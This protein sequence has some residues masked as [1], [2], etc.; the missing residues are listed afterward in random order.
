MKLQASKLGALALQVPSVNQCSLFKML[1]HGGVAA[2]D[3]S[4]AEDTERSKAFAAQ[5]LPSLDAREFPNRLRNE[6]PLP[7]ARSCRGGGARGSA[8][9]GCELRARAAKLPRPPAPRKRG[10]AL[11]TQSRAA[12]NRV[13]AQMRRPRDLHG[14]LC[15]MHQRLASLVFVSLAAGCA[16]A[17]TVPDVRRS[18][19]TSP[20]RGITPT[21]DAMTPMDSGVPPMPDAMTGPTCDG[22]QTVCSGR[23]VD[24]SSDGLNC[25]ACGNACSAG[26]VCN[27]GMCQANCAMGTVRCG[28]SCVDVQSN[29]MHCGRCDNACPNAP[30]STAT[31]SAGTCGSRCAVGFADC[32]MNPANGCEVD[33]S[34]SAMHCGRCGN[35]CTGAN[36]TPT[37][38]AGMC[39]LMCNAGFGDCDMDTANGCEANTSHF[40][41]T[42]R[43]DFTGHLAPDRRALSS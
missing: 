22:G 25:G 41:V 4:R 10:A 20:D 31:C 3:A 21:P 26:Q 19:A 39:S 8:G 1:D 18:D 5:T 29:P 13:S 14:T 34:S 33:T 42:E 2:H 24:T 38:S 9:E 16:V 37:C 23:C 36:G 32:D 43:F 12:T 28:A 7:C 35:A 30:N 27:G 17:E 6:E 15:T 40:K 11:R